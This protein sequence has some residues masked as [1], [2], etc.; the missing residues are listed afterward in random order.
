MP[1]DFT[2]G[3]FPPNKFI[4]DVAGGKVPLVFKIVGTVFLLFWMSMPTKALIEMLSKEKLGNLREAP[5]PA[6]IMILVTAI[7]PIAGVAGLFTLWRGRLPVGKPDEETSSP[8]ETKSASPMPMTEADVPRRQLALAN[9]ILPLFGLVFLL[10]GGFVARAQLLR[11]MHQHSIE[12]QTTTGTVLTSEVRDEDGG[13]YYPH[14]SYRYV[15]DGKTLVNDKLSPTEY[16]TSVH[17]DVVRHAAKYKPGA[18]V[19]VH[20]NRANPSESLLEPAGKTEYAMLLF[21]LP[22]ILFG[23][24]ALFFGVKILLPPR[25]TQSFDTPLTGLKLKRTG[26]GFGQKLFFTCFWCVLTF[27]FATIWYSTSGD[28]SWTK[29]YWTFDKF[30][31]LIFPLIGIGFIISSVREAIRRARTGRYEIDIACAGLRPG[32]RVQVSYRFDGDATNL[33][34]VVFSLEQTSMAMQ[35]AE[36]PLKSTVVVHEIADPMRAQSGT[37]VMTIPPAIDSSNIAWRLVVKYAGITDAF[38]LDVE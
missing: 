26:G 23:L 36:N 5:F 31:M 37:F 7:F 9:C 20:Y 25:Q 32:A 17:S 27:T 30:F 8:V 10:V 2:H 6:V 34:R 13:H 24:I 21:P 28:F 29:D 15:V 18:D 3:R 11:I 16:T 35:R 19:T 14:V 1:S 12:W 38:R 33:D 4:K 22:F